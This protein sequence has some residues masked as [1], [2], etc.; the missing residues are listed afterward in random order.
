MRGAV[1]AAAGLALILARSAAAHVTVQPT[2]IEAGEQTL[3]FSVPNEYFAPQGSARIGGV[4]I[5]V[6]RGVRIGELQT[7]AGWTS[8]RRGRNAT[9]SGGT[10]RYG[11]YDTF[12]LE[13]DVPADVH[14]LVFRALERFDVPRHH[15]EVYPVRLALEA[16]KPSSRRN[17]LAIAAL[18][19]AVAA[20]VLAAGAFF[21]GL[22]RW[23]RGA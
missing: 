17:G 7:K 4:T 21:M 18:I 22:A 23:L 3:T 14:E 1:L 15:V 8:A 2:A 16:T 12:G 20:A 19:V 10:I 6:P 13:V 9:W 5:E 11:E